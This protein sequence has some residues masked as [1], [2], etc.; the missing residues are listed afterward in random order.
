MSSE[1][2][3]ILIVEDSK[4]QAMKLEY[5]LYKSD[6]EPMIAGSGEEALILA[7]NNKPD[8]IISDIVMP[9]MCGYEFCRKVRQEGNF[10][11]IPLI[12]LTALTDTTDIL[13]GLECGANNF[14]TKPYDDEYLIKQIN[15]L[16]ANHDVRINEE[17]EKEV[18]VTFDG[19]DYVIS[20]NK[21][22]IL[23]ILLSIYQT[24]INKNEGKKSGN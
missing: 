7:E 16:L 15:I 11:R 2:K 12:L 21:N 10:S 19:K 5:L 18:N 1:K 6:F 4:T 23:D 14:I 20:A 8:L 13:K 3:R 22:Q 17:P 24:A 9:E